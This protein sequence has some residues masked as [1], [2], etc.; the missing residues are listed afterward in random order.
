VWTGEEMIVWGGASRGTLFADGAA[1]DPEAGGWRTIA[2]APLRERSAHTA[3]WTGEEMIVW[4]GCC[5]RDGDEYGDGAAYDPRS[6]AW[7]RLPS[8]PIRARTGH[9]G[10]WADHELIIWGGHVFDREFS[11]GASYDPSTDSWARIAKAPIEGR[12]S[13]T[14]VWTGQRIVFWGGATARGALA[15]GAWYQPLR[16]RWRRIAPGPLAPRASHSATWTGFSMA[17]VGG[18]CDASGREYGDGAIYIPSY[19]RWEPLS[20]RRLEP[21]Q[22]HTASWIGIAGIVVWGGQQGLDGYPDDAWFLPVGHRS[23]EPGIRVRIPTF[24]DARAGHSSIWSGDEMIVWGGCCAARQRPHADGAA[25]S[26]AGAT[27][28]IDEVVTRGMGFDRTD[29]RTEPTRW[30]SGEILAFLTAG[31][32]LLLL[33]GVV[34][35]VRLLRSRPRP[36]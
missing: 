30:T 13:H 1:Y 17:V 9:A 24:L 31:A 15:D 14:A 6:D 34:V 26:N 7:R 25:L 11:D 4:G 23:I 29:P 21:R 18:C 16:D 5:S 20:T 10:V 35:S 27:E 33:L 28:L 12:F 8:A 36:G 22:G 3:V 19:D 32:V 2:P